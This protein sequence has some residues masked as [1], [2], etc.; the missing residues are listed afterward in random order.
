MLLKRLSRA[1]LRWRSEKPPSR[2][3]EIAHERLLE[4][5]E[6]A[7]DDVHTIAVVQQAAS[8]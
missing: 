2:N 6:P 8:A 5:A 7:D 1:W 4:R 3:R